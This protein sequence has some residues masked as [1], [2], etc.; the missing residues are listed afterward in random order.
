LCEGR[1]RT[2]FLAS[3]LTVRFSPGGHK[4]SF[5]DAEPHVKSSVTVFPSNANL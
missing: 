5:L 3:D 1:K 4:L 2:S